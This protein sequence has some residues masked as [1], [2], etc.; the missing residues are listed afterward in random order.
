MANI[1]L[2]IETLLEAKAIDRNGLMFPAPKEVLEPF[3][4]KTKDYVSDYSVQAM[5][6]S[7]IA[8]AR[9]ADDENVD[10]FNIYPRFIVEGILKEEYQT[11]PVDGHVQDK[12]FGLMCW[13][14]TTTP[15]IKLY[16]SWLRRSCLNLSVF[17]PRMIQS[18]QFT[19]ANFSSIYDSIDMFHDQIE[20]DLLEFTDAYNFLNETVYRKE[21]LPQILG[22]LLIK[23]VKQRSIGTSAVVTATKLLTSSLDYNGIKNQYFNQKLEYS[24][25][26]IYNAITN[27]L[28]KSMDY[29]KRPDMVYKAYQL[30]QN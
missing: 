12:V 22:D 7:E 3:L 6:P 30:F 2:T 9:D 13:T 27:S 26:N 15:G 11:T 1:N 19:D 29:I 16:S 28:S 21:D 25:C 23:S 5:K 17:N 18:R 14:D 10:Q 20:A 24:P 8:I 4:E